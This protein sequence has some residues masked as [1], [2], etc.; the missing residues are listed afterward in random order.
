MS[1]LHKVDLSQTVID[2]GGLDASMSDL[3]LSNGQLQL[4]RIACMT[5]R[6]S[7]VLLLDEYASGIDDASETKMREILA[8]EFKTATLIIVSHRLRALME[9]DQV[10][11]MKAGRVVANGTPQK[12]IE[13]SAEMRSLCVITGTEKSASRRGMTDDTGEHT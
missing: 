3:S 1:A 2:R 8:T 12:L 5:M 4:F 7:R 6:K 11:V 13:E 9:C 10:V